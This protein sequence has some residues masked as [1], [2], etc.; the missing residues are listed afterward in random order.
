[1]ATRKKST[2]GKTQR[3]FKYQ[4]QKFSEARSALMAPQSQPAAQRD[5]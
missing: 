2:K 1:M 3:D 4:G 5:R